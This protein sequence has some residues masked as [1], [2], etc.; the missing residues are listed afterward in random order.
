MSKLIKSKKHVIA[1]KQFIV[2]GD[3]I[4]EVSSVKKEKTAKFY[5]DLTVTGIFDDKK[6]KLVL[7]EDGVW[8]IDGNI[9]ID[10]E[11][12]GFSKKEIKKLEVM[13]ND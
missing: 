7:C 5:D 3:R 13:N 2:V 12:Y 10:L 1:E 9:A 8:R 6:H 11:Q 4:K